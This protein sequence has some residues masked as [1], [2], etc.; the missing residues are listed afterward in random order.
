MAL[1]TMHHGNLDQI[2]P[3]LEF[4]RGNDLHDG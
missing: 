4:S 1:P 2:S 3:D